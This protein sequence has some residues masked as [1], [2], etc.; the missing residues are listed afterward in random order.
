MQIIE[1]IYIESSQNGTCDGVVI[2]I[3]FNSAESW[4]DVWS[5]LS[6][7]PEVVGCD[8]STATGSPELR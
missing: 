4:S 5:G 3:N 2:R 1:E 8:G 7:P 6:G